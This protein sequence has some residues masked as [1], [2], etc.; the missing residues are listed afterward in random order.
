MGS[1]FAKRIIKKGSGRGAAV[2]ALQGDLGA[3]KTTFV[4]GFM[5][6]LGSKKRSASPTF[7]IMRRHSPKGGKKF[8]NVFHMDAYRLKSH[9]QLSVVD[10]DKII[11]NPENIV[12]IEWPER[13]RKALLP[14]LLLSPPIP[15]PTRTTMPPL[16]D[17]LRNRL[18]KAVIAARATNTRG[19]QTTSPAP[20]AAQGPI[21]KAA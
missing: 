14:A 1:K 18:E 20:A 5:N 16:A 15:T 17:D 11:R 2:F 6:G 13:I 9:D 10:F 4:Q 7:I 8:K 19:Q 12:L 21:P 3:G